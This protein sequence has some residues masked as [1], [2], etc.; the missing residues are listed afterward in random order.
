MKISENLQIIRSCCQY[1]DI[2]AFKVDGKQLGKCKYCGQLFIYKRAL[3]DLD[4]GYEPLERIDSN[5]SM[6]N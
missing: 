3:G 1:N 2:Q 5:E 6:V 4:Y